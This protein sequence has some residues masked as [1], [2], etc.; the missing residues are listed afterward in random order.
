MQGNK[1]YRRADQASFLAYPV[2]R[3]SPQQT[4]LKRMNVFLTKRIF[5]DYISYK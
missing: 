3:Q 4:Q 5:F 2:E 1:K